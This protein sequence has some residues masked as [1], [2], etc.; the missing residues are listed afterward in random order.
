MKVAIG[1]A[2]LP[3]LQKLV[4]PPGM[5]RIATALLAAALAIP[6]SADPVAQM[7]RDVNVEAI[8]ST[9][10]RRSSPSARATRSPR[11][12]TRSAASAR[13]ATGSTPQFK[14][15]AATSGGRMTVELQSLRPGAGR[16][17]RIAKPTRLTNVV[18]TLRG[19][20]PESENRVYVVS[21]HYDSCCTDVLDAD[22]RRAGRERRRLR[23]RRRA[24][25]RRA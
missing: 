22:V 10:S 5:K 18:A 19:T 9:R 14:Q 17:P 16:S 8:S 24:R 25:D 1:A 3:Q 15:I 11:R 6:A 2:L 23:H 4:R 7:L 20:Q 21:G 13:R 12:T